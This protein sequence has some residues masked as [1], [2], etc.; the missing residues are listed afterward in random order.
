M[1]DTSNYTL[2]LDRLEICDLMLACTG[3]VIDSKMEM[4]RDPNCPQYRM[5]HVLPETI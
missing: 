3:I 4:E 1:I 5:E 2:T